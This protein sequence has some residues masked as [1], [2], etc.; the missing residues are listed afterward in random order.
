MKN[1]KN[2]FTLMELLV[3][4]AILVILAALLMPALRQA[5]E[6][7]RTLACANNLRQYGIASGLYYADNDGAVPITGDWA[8]TGDG[9]QWGLHYGGYG[10]R[11]RSWID[12]LLPPYIG[13]YFFEHCTNFPRILEIYPGITSWEQI[14]GARL[15]SYAYS[16]RLSARVP[17]TDGA[18][19]GTGW[20]PY[21]INFRSHH[22]GW[23]NGSP[24]GYWPNMSR[25]KRPSNIIQIREATEGQTGIG[26]FLPGT[27]WT[28]WHGTNLDQIN[29]L[30]LDGHVQTTLRSDPELSNDWLGFY[31]WD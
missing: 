20:N 27:G 10:G 31:W 15:H 25:V 11:Y 18:P 19:P 23:Y 21:S 7:G 29:R 1:R 6:R 14:W 2:A 26:R 13:D 24:G 22:L 9:G 4:V 12:D 30:F 16:I 28:G 8:R 5:R 17:T 3:V